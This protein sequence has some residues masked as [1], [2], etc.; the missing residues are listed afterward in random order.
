[1]SG[2][3]TKSSASSGADEKR[4]FNV[5]GNEVGESSTGYV[6]DL[7]LNA[8]SLDGAAGG[9]Q[10][11]Q[12]LKSRHVQLIAIGGTI[13]TGLFIGSGATLSKVG[14]APLFMGYLILA[15]VIYNVMNQIG[16]MV[17]YL[18]AKGGAVSDLVRFYVDESLSFATGWIYYYTFVILVCTEITVTAIIIE[19]W[20]DKVPIAVWII[21]FIALLVTLNFLAV[22]FYGETEFWFALM[23]V[24]CIIGLII[25]GVVIFFGGGPNQD[26]VLGFHYWKDPGS[27]VVHLAH[28]STGRFLDV[29]TA[30]IKSGFAFIVGPELVAVTAGETQNPRRN[31]AKAARR[32]I[33]RLMFFY[34]FGSLVIGIIVP[35]NNQSLLGGKD[36]SASP[37]VI[38]IQNVGIKGLNHVIN[39]AVL[40]SALSAGNSFFFASSRFLYNMAEDGDAPKIFARTNKHGVPYVACGLTTALSFISFLNVS[41][42]SA[43]VFDWLSNLCTI[44]GFI[45]WIIIGFTY[46]RWRKALIYNGLMDR[47]PFKTPFQPYG[48]YYSVGFLIIVSITNG[49]EVFFDFNAADFIAAYLTLPVFFALYFGHKL[50]TRNWK[51]AYPIEEIDVISGVDDAEKADV[52]DRITYKRPDTVWGRIVE[53][54]L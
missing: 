51:W 29:W 4:E 12:G 8:A 49:Y 34:V 43:K 3:H 5:S 24:L 28:G 32:F 31:I 15:S 9:K 48:V 36:A 6:D 44:S 21:I 27:F 35:S 39:A 25:L 30:I 1:M 46:L 33:W 37:F 19:Y 42:A 7:E 16:E 2:L 50:Y 41:S 10:L 22:K 45:G 47:R 40:T 23:K 18:P 54:V 13:G 38:G 53:A 11:H 14:P 17:C 20:T 26:G 52:E